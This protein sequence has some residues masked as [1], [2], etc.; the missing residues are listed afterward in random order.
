MPAKS[1]IFILIICSCV[2]V[3]SIYFSKVACPEFGAD[4]TAT[5]A[6]AATAAAAAAGTRTTPSSPR[7]ATASS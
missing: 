1:T 2:I 4:C 3:I 5:A 6:S 7:S